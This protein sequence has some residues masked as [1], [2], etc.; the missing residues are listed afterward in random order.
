MKTSN[1]IFISFL[2]FLFS[3]ITLLFIGSKYYKDD[4]DNF[5]KLEKPLSSFTVVVAEPGAFFYL[6]SGKQNKI[7][8]NYLKE[9]VPNFAPYEIRND[10]LFVYSDKK[11]NSNKQ[12]QSKGG[13]FVIVPEIFCKNV[14]SIVAKEKARINLKEFKTDTLSITMNAAE[15]NWWFDTTTFVSIQ[16]KDSNIYLEGEY[17]ENLTVQLDKTKLNTPIK[18]RMNNLSGSLK[19]G[20]ECGFSFGYSIHLDA[21]KTSNYTFYNFGN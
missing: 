19:N 1:K 12:E 18:K 14:K 6:K 20:S 16:G 13:Y 15:L 8:Q 5:L 3:G 2:I 4:E 21:D 7:I 9:S 11:E 10:T 17:L